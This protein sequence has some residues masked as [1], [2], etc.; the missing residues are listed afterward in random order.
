[1]TPEKLWIFISSRNIATYKLEKKSSQLENW[2]HLDIQVLPECFYIEIESSLY[3]KI[4]ITSFVVRVRSQRVLN[5]KDW[6]QYKGQNRPH[7][8]RR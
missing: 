5:V 4:E 1:M 6:E 7:L 8:R 3:G 2:N